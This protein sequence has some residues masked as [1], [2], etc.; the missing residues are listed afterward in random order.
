[1]YKCVYYKKFNNKNLLSIFIENYIYIY[2]TNSNKEL[3]YVQK[4]IK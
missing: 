2:D 4:A 3:D 1:M